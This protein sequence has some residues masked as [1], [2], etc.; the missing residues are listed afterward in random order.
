MQ[1]SRAESASSG[2]NP[3]GLKPSDVRY[4]L[5]R[6][7]DRLMTI[8]VSMGGISVIIAV[9][10]IFFYL[11]AVV[12]PLFKGVNVE[13]V[14]DYVFDSAA[15]HLLQLGVEERGEIVMFLT[16]RGGLKFVDTQE[17]H[18]LAQ[19]HLPV[20]DGTRLVSGIMV[21]ES[22]GLSAVGLSDGTILVYRPRYKLEY[23]NNQRHI[24]PEVEYPLGRQ[25]LS[26]GSDRSLDQFALRVEDS[27]AKLA[28]FNEET[29]TLL[30]RSFEKKRRYLGDEGTFAPV[31]DHS[32]TLDRSPQ[33][34]RMSL[35]QRFLYAISDDGMTDVFDL[36][37]GAPKLWHQVDLTPG[38]SRISAVKLLTGG[39]SLIVGTSEGGLSQWFPVR[40][41]GEARLTHIRDFA[42]MGDAAITSLSTEAR[43]KGFAAFD[44]QGRMG[45]YNATAQRQMLVR[46]LD[47][48][49]VKHSALAPR[50]D[51]ALIT[52]STGAHFY[53]IH[54][55]YPEVSWRSLWGK[56]W[57]EGYA[58]PTYT[59]QSSAATVGHEPKY[60]LMPLS[61]GTLKAAFY[62]MLFALPLSIMG[63][64][65]T[66]YFLAPRLR[67]V[68]KPTIEIMEALPT[69]ILG[70]LAGLW[71]APFAENYL[72]GIFLILVVLPL[73]IVAGGFIWSRFPKAIRHRVGPGW[74]AGLLLL[75]IIVAI[76][77]C[78]KLSLPIEQALFN[79]N[80]PHW[81]EY[82]LGI[83]YDQRS[84]LVVGLMMGFAVIPTIFSISEDAVFGVP[85]HLSMGSL[86][87]GATPWQTITR[88]VMPTALPGIF[89]AVMIGLGRAVGETMIVLMAT[90]NTPVMNMNIFEGMRTLSANIAVEMPESEVGSTHYRVLFLAGLV[91]FSFTFAINTLA[92]MIRQR[93][94]KKYA[95]I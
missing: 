21:D 68:I 37:S 26:S 72:P 42:V 3:S 88:V 92:E 9:S 12:F 85:K 6:T 91:L 60:S 28:A 2:N 33:F 29:S 52:S 71:L 82:N 36:A 79:G 18:I 81:I 38:G 63:A 58:E 87:L 54:N 83:G 16:T 50:G 5:R 47:D 46:Q 62:A 11:L 95:G 70:F 56:V 13:H 84:A 86:A 73:V 69:V 78:V 55:P 44:A 67:S 23:I 53:S 41:E 90:G 20:P 32:I 40:S 59:W 75:P 94:R 61:F 89:S 80:M 66:A 30:V 64:V 24:R 35:D 65:C 45:V 93:L 8:V 49:A 39:I 48:G 27:R 22:D 77:V 15:E 31:S 17:H 43:R 4:R 19:E 76:W 25:T 10:L 51:F 57:Y 74:E 14:S 7:I 34:L 1:N